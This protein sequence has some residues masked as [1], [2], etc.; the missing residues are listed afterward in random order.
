MAA[1]RQGTRIDRK[2]KKE[3][4]EGT[5]RNT[6]ERTDKTIALAILRSGNRS[7][8]LYDRVNTANYECQ[9]PN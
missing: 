9:Y 7:F 4:S 8:G 6:I 3:K 5:H 2:I 1:G